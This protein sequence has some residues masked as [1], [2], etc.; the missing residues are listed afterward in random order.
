M[1]DTET[2]ELTAELP[3]AP[4]DV[5]FATRNKLLRVMRQVVEMKAGICF[6]R[7]IPSDASK[8]ARPA[9]YFVGLDVEVDLQRLADELVDGVA[10]LAATLKMQPDQASPP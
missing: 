4:E 8:P 1:T 9:S 6:I 2:S 5:L 7:S 3:P 10:D